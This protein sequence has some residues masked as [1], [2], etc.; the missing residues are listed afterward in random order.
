MKVTGTH[1]EIDAAH[2]ADLLTAAK[3][4]IIVP[5]YGLAVAERYRTLDGIYTSQ[6]E[7]S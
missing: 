7:G 2:A 4:I 6:G 5:G 3:S 1:T